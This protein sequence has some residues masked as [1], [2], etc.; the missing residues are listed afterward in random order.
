MRQPSTEDWEPSQCNTK[1]DSTG[2]GWFR[3]RDFGIIL[4]QQRQLEEA[5]IILRG[6]KPTEDVPRRLGP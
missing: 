3:G 1:S 2:R 6:A 5:V 4:D